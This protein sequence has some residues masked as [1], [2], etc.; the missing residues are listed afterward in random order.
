M[1][2]KALLPALNLLVMSPSLWVALAAA[3]GFVFGIY[4]ERKKLYGNPSSSNNSEPA[5]TLFRRNAARRS[6]N[7]RKRK[8]GSAATRD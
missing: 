2:L 4:F 8:K 1:M 6:A 7:T 3:G 5:T